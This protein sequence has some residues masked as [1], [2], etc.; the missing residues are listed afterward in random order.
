MDIDWLDPEEQVSKHFTVKEALWLPKWNRMATEEDG[1]NDEIKNNIIELFNKLDIVR[2]Y[3]N[4]PIN[5]HCTYR[6]E[7]YNKLIGGALMSAHKVGKAC[8]FDISDT[9]C[10]DARK[11]IMMNHLLETW[12]LRMEWNDGSNWIHLDSVWTPGKIRYFKP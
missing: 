10:D 11:Q 5:V 12:N 8:D 3:F 9:K 4:K 6:P 1:L 7:A 2:E